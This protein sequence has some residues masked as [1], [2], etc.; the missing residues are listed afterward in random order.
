MKS[1]FIMKDCE[2]ISSPNYDDRPN[3]VEVDTIVIHC[4]S[5]PELNYEN[6]YVNLLF[7]NALNRQHDKSFMELEGLKVSSHLLIKRSGE[8]IQYVPFN[9]RAWHAGE[10]EY[11][12]RTNINDF[13]IGIELH[14]AITDTYTD[15]QY[16]ELKKTIEYLKEIFPSIKDS[17]IIGHSDVAPGRKFDPGPHFI[18][19][20]IK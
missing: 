6:D 9:K 10:S 8:I 7:Q 15:N 4:I 1:E 12:G 5:L 11:N 13:S 18:W 20:K 16:L 14:G 3:G 19:E 17:N 2:Y